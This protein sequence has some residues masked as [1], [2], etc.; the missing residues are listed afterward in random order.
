M[1]ISTVPEVPGLTY[2]VKGLVFAQAT[3][4]AMGGGNTQKMVQSL[5]D[6]ATRLG[7]NGIV[8]VKTVLGGDHG[9]C[10]MTGTAVLLM[11]RPA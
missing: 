6:Q 3:L 8:D 4:G 11:Q 9:H 5:A 1:L 7:A 10:V 2:E